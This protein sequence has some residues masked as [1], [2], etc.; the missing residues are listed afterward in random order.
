MLLERE[1]IHVDQPLDG[2]LG[3]GFAAETGEDEEL[4]RV[5]DPDPGSSDEKE[6]APC[7]SP[8]P[9]GFL[10]FSSPRVAESRAAGHR[11]PFRRVVIT[12]SGDRLSLDPEHWNQWAFTP[13]SLDS[14]HQRRREPH[15]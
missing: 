8:A 12:I 4:V 5:R 3:V 15:F 7:Y 1:Y 14:R 9:A 6:E 11:R 13:A 2:L 10:A